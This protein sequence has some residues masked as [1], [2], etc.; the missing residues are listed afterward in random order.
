MQL[1]SIAFKREVGFCSSIRCTGLELVYLIVGELHTSAACGWNKACAQVFIC[2]NQ[3]LH[4]TEKS[5]S[6]DLKTK[7]TEQGV[8][9]LAGDLMSWGT[10]R[11]VCSIS[12]GMTHFLRVRHD[13]K[14]YNQVDLGREYSVKDA[15]RCR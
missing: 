8:L 11:I 9:F 12:C 4:S 3:Y 15:R 6:M 13:L 5:F 1:V 2:R 10:E 14:G 7:C